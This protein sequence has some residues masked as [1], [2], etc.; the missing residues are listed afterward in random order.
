MN[1]RRFNDE[2]LAR[3]DAYLSSLRS[4]PKIDPPYELLEEDE[5]SEAVADVEVED[6]ELSTRMEAG[7]YLHSLID[8]AGLVDAASDRKLW[9]WLSLWFFE[10]VCPYD[11]NGKRKAGA[12]VRYV[13][14][15]GNYLRYYR[16]LLAG[17]W[18]IFRIHRDDPE[19]ARVI[20]CQPL[21]MPGDI[22]EQIASRQELVTNRLF[23]AA[24]TRLFIDPSTESPKTGASAKARR[25]AIFCDQ[26]DVT[27]DLYAMT[28]D[29]VFVKLPKEYDR[30]R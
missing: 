20:L 29:D 3:F 11:G 9:A 19:A 10:S 4:D 21:H 13:P 17:S 22:V 18:R 24:A 2:G 5:T 14:D 8:A 16:H 28:P 1:L 12:R 26:L 30:F 27:W 6:L 15:V 7:E 25:L 23:L